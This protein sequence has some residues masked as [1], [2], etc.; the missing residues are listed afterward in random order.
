MNI[1]KDGKIFLWFDAELSFDPTGSTVAL[2]VDG[3]TSHPM[4]WQG[5]PATTTTGFKQT[6]KTDELFAGS[7]A[8]TTN[9]PVILTTGIHICEPIVT[10]GNQILSCPT[11]LVNVNASTE[12]SY[13]GDPASRPI[14]QIRFL[15]QDTNMAN[16]LL[17][18]SEI[19]FIFAQYKNPLL[20]AAEAADVIGSKYVSYAD[21]TVGPLRIRKSDLAQRYYD[22]GKSLRQRAS[23][24][25]GAL[26][27]MTQNPDRTRAFAIGMNDNNQSTALYPPL[28][29]DISQ[30]A[31]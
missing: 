3:G 2:K 16:A 12:Y 21:K 27:V 6:A 23:R 28:S 30:T 5:L 20:A 22:L 7:L 17:N 26:A 4:T 24:N 15:I 9:T 29:T 31:L 18:D 25:T 14:D 1:D 8:D 13:S 19:L 11:F 10:K